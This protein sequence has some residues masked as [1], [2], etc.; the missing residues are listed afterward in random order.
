MILCNVY[1]SIIKPDCAELVLHVRSI[2][3]VPCNYA[4]VLQA[5][6]YAY[7]KKLICWHIYTF[8]HQHRLQMF[9]SLFIMEKNFSWEQDAQSRPA[10]V[11]KSPGCIRTA[12]L[13]QALFIGSSQQ[14]AYMPWILDQVCIETSVSIKILCSLLPSA[15]HLVASRAILRSVL[16][17]YNRRHPRRVR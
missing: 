7:A 13:P 9:G 16:L 2:G 15:S 14:S 10:S 12:K 11:D 3:V 1:L 6:W 4:S 17:R 8:F 5:G